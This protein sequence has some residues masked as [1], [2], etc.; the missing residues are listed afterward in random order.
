MASL[1]KQKPKVVDCYLYVGYIVR[2]CIRVVL[3]VSFTRKHVNT[4]RT[5]H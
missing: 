4:S 3:V 2:C 5:I 1:I